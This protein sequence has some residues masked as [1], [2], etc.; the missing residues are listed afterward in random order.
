MLVRSRALRAILLGSTALAVTATLTWAPASAADCVVRETG[1]WNDPA[2][3]TNCFGAFPA[4]YGDTAKLDGN[5][6][7]TVTAAQDVDEF[8]QTDGTLRGEADLTITYR[9]TFSGGGLEVVQGK[10]TLLNESTFTN[11]TIDVAEGAVL[12]LSGWYGGQHQFSGVGNTGPGTVRVDAVGGLLHPVELKLLTPTAFGTLEVPKGR[13]S[14]N[15]PSTVQTLVQDG[16]TSLHW[17]MIDHGMREANYSVISGDHDLTV[18]G[19]A[20][21]L[22]G[23]QTGSGTTIVEGTATIGAPFLVRDGNYDYYDPRYRPHNE[24]HIYGDRHVVVKGGGS[25]EGESGLFVLLYGTLWNA[26]GSL[27]LNNTSLSL[28]GW[29]GGLFVN[30]GTFRN[31]GN[32]AEISATL[33]NPGMV[34]VEQGFLVLTGPVLQLAG[35]TLQAGTWRVLGDAATA[36][37]AFF[38]MGFVPIAN[39]G[40]DVTLS[41]ADSR[42]CAGDAQT[43][44]CWDYPPDSRTSDLED[45]LLTILDG[46]A[47]RVL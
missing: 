17:E 4:G 34:E 42:F 25:F 38:G 21:L 11:A 35:D 6:V 41:G 8:T 2:T 32:F 22:G 23:D 37:I 40:A 33:D 46:G 30:E 24:Y 16:F 36:E 47:L 44:G 12:E 45:S 26:D 1:N 9:A 20:F 31:S 7:L 5:H 28:G 43:Y 27:L 3:W 29:G 14:V 18:T 39:L 10:V 15:A 19:A 13:L